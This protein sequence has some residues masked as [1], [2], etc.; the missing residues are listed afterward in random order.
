MELEGGRGR[1][2][3]IAKRQ[4]KAEERRAASVGRCS[5]ERE[6]ERERAQKGK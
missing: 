3:E 2:R 5:Q 1:E 6:R 4:G